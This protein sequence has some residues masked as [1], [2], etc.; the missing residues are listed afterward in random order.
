V[1]DTGD[2]RARRRE[3]ALHVV[4]EPEP[5]ADGLFR[6]E[7]WPA[8]TIRFCYEDGPRDCEAVAVDERAGQVLLVSKRTVPPVLYRLPLR[9]AATDG[10]LTARRLATVFGLPAPTAADLEQPYGR[11]RSRPTALDLAPNGLR[12]A[13]L[14]YKDAYLFARRLGESWAAA[15]ARQ[16]QRIRLPD[17]DSLPQREALCFGPDGQSLLVTSEGANAPLFLLAPAAVSKNR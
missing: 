7:V 13:L 3:V 17:A 11:Y 14:T 10:V 9:P 15:F 5:D 1:A 8:W 2:N 12:A 4:A 16:P 6:G